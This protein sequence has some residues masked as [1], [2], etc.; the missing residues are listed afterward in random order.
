M[1]QS[2][3]LL[4]GLDEHSTPRPAGLEQALNPSFKIETMAAVQDALAQLACKGYDAVVYWA[5]R[6]DELEGAIRIRLARPEVPIVLLTARRDTSFGKLARENGVTS[7]VHPDHDISIVAETL[8]LVIISRELAKDL[9]SQTDR[10]RT[11]IQEIESLARQNRELLETASTLA[12]K[13]SQGSLVPLLVEDDLNH[14]LLMVRAFARA[15][16]F[17]PLPILKTGE[18]AIDFLSE[19]ARSKGRRAGDSPSLILLDISLPRRSGL[20]VLEWIRKQPELKRIPVVMLTSSVNP[21][22]VNRAYCLGASSYL[23]KP[24]D[25]NDLVELAFG[26]KGYWGM[27]NQSWFSL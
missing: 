22:D 7:I 17:T 10:A 8:R 5:E 4:V 9:R 25:F 18:E 11:Q 21:E 12:S 13:K 23:I 27:S 3:V 15:G 14:A 20:E 6:E 26:L 19:L 24:F 16:V 2:R 1:L